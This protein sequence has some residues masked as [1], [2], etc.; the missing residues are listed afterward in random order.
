MYFFYSDHLNNIK[1]RIH[2]QILIVTAF[3]LLPTKFRN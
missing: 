1:Y 2:L 3:C